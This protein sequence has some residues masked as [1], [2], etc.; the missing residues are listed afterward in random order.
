MKRMLFA[1]L[2]LFFPW[3]VFLLEEKFVLAVGAMAL[4]VTIIGWLPI[5][6]IAFRHRDN[7]S[8]FNAN[9]KIKSESVSEKTE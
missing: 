3:S 9:S 8:Y 5:T 1:C 4:Q 6:I 7:I 2:A